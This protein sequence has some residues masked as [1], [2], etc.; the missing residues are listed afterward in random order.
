MRVI[1]DG[2]QVIFYPSW[3]DDMRKMRDGGASI[4]TLMEEFGIGNSTVRALTNKDWRAYLLKWNVSN[5]DNR[6]IPE[7]KT[8]V[9][10]YLFEP[11]PEDS[12]AKRESSK[13]ERMQKAAEYRRKYGQ[14]EQETEM[15]KVREFAVA[16]KLHEGKMLKGAK[17][18]CYKCGASHEYYN[19][20]GTVSVEHLPKE[21]TRRG[22]FVGNNER[23]DQCPSCIA[24]LRSK[25]KTAV[26]VIEEKL[27][28]VTN[29]NGA[30][31]LSAEEVE[32][33]HD[34]AAAVKPIET[35]TLEIKK[36]EPSRMVGTVPREMD[37]TDRRLIFARLNEIYGDDMY[38]EDWTDDKAAAD[39][40]VPVEWVA[41]VREADFGPNINATLKANAVAAK[42]K[43]LSG[44]GEKIERQLML[45]EKKLEQM[46]ALDEKVTKIHNEIADQIERFEE[47]ERSLEV[48]D[49]HI[50]ELLREF[51]VQS[52]EFKKL[53]SELRPDLSSGVT[54]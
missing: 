37:K 25:P 3:H 17:I 6:S 31:P 4:E 40:D 33:R 24:K 50:K 28:P 19:Y 1:K 11:R 49:K 35:K 13:K 5:R 16:S 41:T 27:K 45:I 10:Q 36:P 43:A 8:L 39:L 44:V 23:T 18:K 20:S 29:G 21:F 47:I 14:P 34:A 15:A 30:K 51:G 12:P 38:L 26:E 52:E 48:E 42:E 32:R 22:W 53:F 9:D 7:L 46:Q 2:K 54:G